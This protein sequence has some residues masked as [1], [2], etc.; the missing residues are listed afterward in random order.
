MQQFILVWKVNKTIYYFTGFTQ[1]PIGEIPN[2]T[3]IKK[4]AKQYS[5]AAADLIRER[6]GYSWTIEPAP[7]Q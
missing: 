2:I 4:D 1:T 5:R 3:T 6:L 7:Q